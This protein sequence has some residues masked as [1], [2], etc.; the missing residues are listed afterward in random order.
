MK[1]RKITRRPHFKGQCNFTE[2]PSRLIYLNSGTEGSMPNCVIKTFK[3]H[4]KKWAR[5]PTTSQEIGP[6]LGKRQKINRKTIA[7]Y[8]GVQLNNI[9]LTNN[10]TMGLSMVLMGL[11]FQAEDK[12]VITDHEHPAITSPLWV[13]KKKLG[14]QLE[15]R[16]F[17]EP[18]Q[19]R[20]MN[21][22]QLLDSLFPDIPELH[23]AKAL[24]IS[25]V[26][27]TTGVRLP[28]E[29]IK[30][31]AD[32]LNISYLIVDGAQALGAVDFSDPENRLDNCDFYAAPAH[33]WMNGPPGTGLLYIRN[34][35]L[36]PPEFYPPLSQKMGAYL[37]GDDVKSC[38]PMAEA[39]Q[40]RGCIN[41]P[42]N[43]AL[44]RLMKF[45]NK[46]GG[47]AVVE[48]HILNLSCKVRDFI[49]VKA[50]DSLISPSDTELQSGLVSFYPFKW[51]EPQTSFK[52]EET[53]VWVV[54]E[55]LQKGVQVRFVPFP[56]VDFSPDCQLKKHEPDLPRDCSGES[57]DQTYAIRVSTGLFN[58]PEQIDIFWKALKKVLKKLS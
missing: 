37:S 1:V 55:L 52:D 53:A 26:Y 15:V 25:H 7:E 35:N 43:V 29:K 2:L 21:S 20:Q 16:P 32:E 56:T 13:L 23:N 38:L 4:L 39:L 30:H 10:T 33:K 47:Q 24:C 50:P 14:I 44:L 19:L 8:L 9:C 11:D 31:K 3:K 41:T 17:P 45:Y 6:V 54:K 27:N 42:A 51:S 22:E 5:N 34:S 40:V 49:A 18:A 46:I 12:I 57:V 36:C 48:K 58:T 28:L